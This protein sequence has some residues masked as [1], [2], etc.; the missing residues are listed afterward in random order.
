MKF[1]SLIDQ[2]VTIKANQK[3]AQQCYVDSLTVVTRPPKED[4]VSEHVEVSTDVELDH[5][6]SIDHGVEPIEK[7]ENV[8]LI[9]DEHCT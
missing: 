7:L 3:M 8:S 9:D 4:N 5:R 2:V 6:P 1:P